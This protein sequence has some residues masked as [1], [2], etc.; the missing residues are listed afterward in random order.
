MAYNSMSNGGTEIGLQLLR[1][2]FRPP[3]L[4]VEQKVDQIIP[5]D[6]AFVLWLLEQTAF[7]PNA[8]LRGSDGLR[9]WMR[10]RGR[11]FAQPMV[12]IVEKVLYSLPCYGPLHDPQGNVGALGAEDILLGYDRYSNTFN[13]SDSNGQVIT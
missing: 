1:G 9:R 13:I 4:S 8:V 7:L 6:H 12:G 11:V 10:V 5:V 3:K 2:V